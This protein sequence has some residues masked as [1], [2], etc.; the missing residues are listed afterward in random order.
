[1]PPIG[2]QFA[3]QIFIEL[4]QAERRNWQAHRLAKMCTNPLPPQA[5]SI[6]LLPL[7]VIQQSIRSPAE[8]GASLSLYAGAQHFNDLQHWGLIWHRRSWPTNCCQ[9]S[10]ASFFER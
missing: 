1:M 3:H 9:G 2:W 7:D 4:N 6:R 8:E 10:G 5:G